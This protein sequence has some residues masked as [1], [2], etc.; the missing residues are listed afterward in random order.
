MNI[1]LLRIPS[2]VTWS[3]SE[4]EEKIKENCLLKAD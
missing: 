4:F 3:I 1:P 2:K